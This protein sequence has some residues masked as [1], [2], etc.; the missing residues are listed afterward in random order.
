MI[1]TT[2]VMIASY[3]VNA[4]SMLTMIVM[5]ANYMLKY[6]YITSLL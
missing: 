2:I 5:A 6:A 1:C 4:V 3:A